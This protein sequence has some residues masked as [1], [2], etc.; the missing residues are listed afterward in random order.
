MQKVRR[1]LRLSKLIMIP[2]I[3]I[4]LAGM[5]AAVIATADITIAIVIVDT[6]TVVIAIHINFWLHPDSVRGFLCRFVRRSRAPR[7]RAGL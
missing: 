2:I 1:L 5:S 3:P 4:V 6:V 7:H